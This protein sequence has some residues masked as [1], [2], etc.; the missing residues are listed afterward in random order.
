MKRLISAMR[1]D[2]GVK[3]LIGWGD[4]ALSGRQL[5]AEEELW[6]GVFESVVSDLRKC[7]KKNP[8]W[9]AVADALLVDIYWLEFKVLDEYLNLSEE[10]ITYAMSKVLAL[11]EEAKKR[12]G[13]KY[14]TYVWIAVRKDV[15]ECV[16]EKLRD[17]GWNTSSGNNSDPEY[18]KIRDELVAKY[19]NKL[20][21]D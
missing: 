15:L 16:Y 11:R 12:L 21:E 14:E 19:F 4:L 6:W 8:D 10:K 17:L 1:I 9:V 18:R 20:K 5:T 3:S 2:D 7:R 13:G